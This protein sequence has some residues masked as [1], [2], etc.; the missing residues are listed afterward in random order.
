MIIQHKRKWYACAEK[1]APLLGLDS[2]KSVHA[3]AKKGRWD[4]VVKSLQG[5]RKK[6]Y[7]VDHLPLDAQLKFRFEIEAA[8]KMIDRLI[9]M[10]SSLK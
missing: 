8:P 5:G 3:A 9:V 7:A 4:S 6:Y 10:L 1:L 2:P